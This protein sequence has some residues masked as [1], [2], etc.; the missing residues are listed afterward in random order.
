MSIRV[1]YS[2]INVRPP[3]WNGFMDCR[4]CDKK[5]WSIG[6]PIPKEGDDLSKGYTYYVK[7]ACI[8]CG[9]SE[10]RGKE[11]RNDYLKRMGRPLDE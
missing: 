9:W 8:H 2:F 11:E 4:Q 3:S 1:P 5:A 10:V 7:S 6:G